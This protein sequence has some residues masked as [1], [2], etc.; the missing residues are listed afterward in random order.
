MERLDRIFVNNSWLS[1]FP[2]A[3]VIHLPRTHSDHNPLLVQLTSKNVN[4]INKPSRL[5][6]I[7][8]RH[9]DFI[10]IVKQCWSNDDLTDAQITL[11][12]TVIN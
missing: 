1:L 8:Y 12:D 5:E 10:N 9:P 4:F 3:M 6:T 7:W 11:K 2:K